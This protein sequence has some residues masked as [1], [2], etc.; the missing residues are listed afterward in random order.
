MWSVYVCKLY[1]F[2]IAGTGLALAKQQCQFFIIQ[3][4]QYDLNNANDSKFLFFRLCSGQQQWF[5][6]CVLSQLHVHFQFGEDTRLHQPQK[7]HQSVQQ[8]MS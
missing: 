7:L 6:L 8:D 4:K 5:V 3:G 2:H 1:I